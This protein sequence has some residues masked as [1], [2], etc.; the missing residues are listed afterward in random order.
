MID[1]A[2]AYVGIVSLSLLWLSAARHKLVD[3]QAF[4]ATVERYELLPR[5]GVL[6][7]ALLLPVLELA[8]GL[9]LLAPATRVAAAHAALALLALYSLAIG[10]NLLRGRHDIDCG[11]TGPALR[12]QLSGWLIVRNLLLMTLS[13][14]LLLPIRARDLHW[15]DAFTIAFAVAA[16]TLLYIAANHALA[17]AHG[18]DRVGRLAP[19]RG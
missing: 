13:A 15:L 1:V 10:V 6:P 8:V 11:C 14:G 16:G 7:L 9:A 4:R 5:A 17:N 12:Q 3:F 2:I 18:M 19:S